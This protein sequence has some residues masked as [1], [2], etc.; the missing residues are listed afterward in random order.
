M[1]RK[2]DPSLDPERGLIVSCF[3]K[4]RSGKSVMGSFLARSYPHDLLV[5]DIAGDDGPFGKDVIEVD[6]HADDGTLPSSWPEWRRQYTDS[7]HPIKMTTRYVPD[8]GN[9]ERMLRDIDHMVGLVMAKGS[10]AVLIHEVGHAAPVKRVPPNMRRLLMHNRHR[11]V[12]AIFCGPRPMDID[13]LVL[14]QS[15]MVYTFELPVVQD[16]QKVAQT[17]GWDV[18]DFSDAVLALGPHEHLL[19]DANMPKPQDGEDDRRLVSCGALPEGA[20]KSTQRWIHGT[21]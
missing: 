3:G 19:F 17:I 8:T 10:T 14:G 12:T 9:E 2:T 18:Q 11:K 21:A 13:P 16:R 1:V 5:I 20:Y 15:D 6:G 4:K 7:G